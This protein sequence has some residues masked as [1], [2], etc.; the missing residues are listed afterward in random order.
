[1]FQSFRK[2][3]IAFFLVVT[4]MTTAAC[5]GTVQA[6][7]PADSLPAVRNEYAQLERGNTPEGVNFADWVAQTGQDLIKDVYVRD[8]NKLGVVITPK[9][10][11]N[12]VQ[13]LA[14]SL[15]QGF[16]RNFPQQDLTVFVYA[17]DKKLVLSAQYDIQSNQVKY[18]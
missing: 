16:H 14:K 5:S 9:V 13:P 3:L 10:R 17:P 12:E 18:Q 7:K 6:T 4:L 15:L 2:V 11:P 8:N 1:M